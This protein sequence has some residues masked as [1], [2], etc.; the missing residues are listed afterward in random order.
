M[1]A[2]E[3]AQV[4]RLFPYLSKYPI[5]FDVGSNKG[6]W[7]DIVIGIASEIHL[8]EPNE[9]MLH[10]TQVKYDAAR[11]I[12]YC[13]MAAWKEAN[14][15]PFYIIAD[16]YSGLSGVYRNHNWDYLGWSQTE[17]Q[18][19]TLDHYADSNNIGLIDIIKVDVEGAEYDVLVGCKKLLRDKRV[20]FIQIEYSEHYKI[21]GHT[22]KDVMDYVGQ[23][24]YAVFDHNLRKM[25]TFVEDF[26]LDNYI[27]ALAEFTENWNSEFIKNTKDMGVN[28]ALEIGC[29]EGITTNYICDNLLNE[30]GRVVC[31]DPLA[32][33]YLTESLSEEDKAM[34]ADLA[35]VFNGQYERFIR[36]TVGKPVQL[37]RKTSAAA[38]PEIL[39]LRFDLIYVDGDHRERYV[40]WDAVSCFVLLADGGV[41]LF[42]DY[43]WREYTKRGIDRF[44]TEYESRVEVLVKDY[45]VMVKKIPIV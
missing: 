13:N 36:N 41:M 9:K 8:F 30:G 26:H 33:E 1:D 10:Y 35:K 45:Q 27:I 16:E 5:V 14:Q 40:Y 31:V 23:Y 24:G 34:N 29:F 7:T 39:D 4:K 15:I 44:L 2:N 3:I 25:D 20:R 12:T 17:I 19:T 37:I 43:G 38:Y 18:T 21:S 42:D 32:D 22:L 28:L 6:L 11:N